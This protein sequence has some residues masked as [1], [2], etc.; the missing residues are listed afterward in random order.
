[1]AV[2]QNTV[3]A[4]MRY[5]VH[6]DMIATKLRHDSPLT[7]RERALCAQLIDGIGTLM[8]GLAAQLAD[9]EADDER[10]H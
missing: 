9:L 5:A 7:A 2:I 1:M 4:Y 8:R 3:R 10:S 6:A